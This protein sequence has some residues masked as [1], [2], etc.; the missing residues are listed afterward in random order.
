M[1]WHPS[2]PSL[3]PR[4]SSS[5][6]SGGDEEAAVQVNTVLSIIIKLCCL[7]VHT[8]GVQ[9]HSE[10]HLSPESNTNGKRTGEGRVLPPEEHLKGHCWTVGRG[11]NTCGLQSVIIHTYKTA[12]ADHMVHS[13]MNF[14]PLKIV[15]DYYISIYYSYIFKVKYLINVK[16]INFCLFYSYLYDLK[17]KHVHSAI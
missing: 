1:Y 14:I 11:A 13:A 17:Y 9:L 10:A 3:N 6:S 5:S 8:A 12:G 16:I 2:T 4:S 7:A 15:T